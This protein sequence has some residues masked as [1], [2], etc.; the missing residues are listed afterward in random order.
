MIYASDRILEYRFK[1]AIF[2]KYIAC[3]LHMLVIWQIEIPVK[4]SSIHLI[5]HNHQRMLVGSR[6]LL[7]PLLHATAAA[8]VKCTM[9]IVCI[10]AA[11][12]Y[13]QII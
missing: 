10:I 6:Q 2:S 13:I 8:L 1:N 4:S 5:R 9:F 7:G 12:T 11:A 3:F